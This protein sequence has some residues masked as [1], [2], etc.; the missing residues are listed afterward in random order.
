MEAPEELPTLE[1]GTVTED[2]TLD[3]A[4]AG[5]RRPGLAGRGGGTLDADCRISS[6]VCTACM[7]RMA[8]FTRA[9]KP[10]YMG[11]DLGH[12]LTP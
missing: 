6:S 10:A 4:S 3:R 1:A 5:N 11:L 12:T 8:S 9:D 2:V 7:A